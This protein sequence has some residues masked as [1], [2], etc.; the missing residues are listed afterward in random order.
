MGRYVLQA[1]CRK[2][3]DSNIRF[4]RTVS[5][6]ELKEELL[7]MIPEN[8]EKDFRILDKL[9][10]IDKEQSDYES[11]REK[12]CVKFAKN[13][14]QEFTKM[15]VSISVIADKMGA[16]RQRIHHYLAAENLPTLENLFFLCRDL[17]VSA[18]ELLGITVRI[19]DDDE[20][21]GL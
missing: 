8:H 2:R 14:K 9:K 21:S 6:S 20:F 1:L 17:N 10:Y 5:V 15:K 12:L 7:N 16:T 18:D 4:W 19:D 11:E 13:L 3:Y